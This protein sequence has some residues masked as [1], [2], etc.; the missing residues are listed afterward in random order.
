MS[1]KKD[2]GALIQI[3]D[4]ETKPATK[5]VTPIVTPKEERE[6]AFKESFFSPDL[7][8]RELPAHHKE[9]IT[10]QRA[11][12]AL[13]VLRDFISSGGS[14]TEET[15][16]EINR[17]LDDHTNRVKTM[18]VGI[19]QVR[20]NNLSTLIRDIDALEKELASRNIGYMSTEQLVSLYNTLT[21]REKEIIDFLLKMSDLAMPKT[22]EGD[23]TQE[24]AAK[25]LEELGI[26]IPNVAGR[27]NIRELMDRILRDIQKKK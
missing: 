8:D 22:L 3:R 17:M 4:K 27:R 5:S 1:N 12:Q 21:K 9:N 19:S 16:M 20:A 6:K 25:K 26:N 18:I 11:L 2:S 13:D 10:R 14:I 23:S 15:R 7:I 24:K